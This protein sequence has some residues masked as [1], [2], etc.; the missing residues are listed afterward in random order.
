[1]SDIQWE[2]QAVRNSLK[3][4]DFH[5]GFEEWKKWSDRCVRSQ[6]DYFEGDDSQNWA[7]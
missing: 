7:S 2:S 1:V 4:N 3:E 5:G 6:G